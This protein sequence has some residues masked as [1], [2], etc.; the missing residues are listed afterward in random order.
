MISLK[1]RFTDLKC[2]EIDQHIWFD[3]ITLNY[4]DFMEARLYTNNVLGISQIL[5][6]GCSYLIG[7]R[8]NI[9]VDFKHKLCDDS[10]LFTF[11]INSKLVYPCSYSVL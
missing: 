9:D 6:V 5:F 11:E 2:F 8:M 4:L 1:L 7:L 3:L 10:K